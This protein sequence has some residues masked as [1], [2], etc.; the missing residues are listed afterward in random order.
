[1]ATARWS[2]TN[3]VRFI[4]RPS[5]RRFL[6]AS[7]AGLPLLAAAATFQVTLN[8]TPLAGQQGYLAFD[9]YKG[10][11]G[12]VNQADV[13]AFSSTAVLGASSVAGNAVGS[14]S[15]TVSLR[16]TTFF[17][18][19]LQAVTFAAGLTTFNLTLS[20]N[21]VAGNTPDSFALFLLKSSFQPYDT[22]DPSGADALLSVDLRSPLAPQV[23]T[24]AVTTISVVDEPG[25][26][27]LLGFGLLF[28]AGRLPLL[29]RPA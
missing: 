13:S 18:E 14:L 15:G 12:T 26:L 24:S 25:R 22:S 9:L 7:L 27:A 5:L 29:R 16:S 21:F 6:A 8:T 4:G 10:D 28:V 3:T 23:Y 2:I 1:M 20:D 11:P 17:S 19:F